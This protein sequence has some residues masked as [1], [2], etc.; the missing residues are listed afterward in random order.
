MMGATAAYSAMP[1]FAQSDQAV[2]IEEMSI[3]SEDAP[4]TLIEYASFTC[5][6]CK[7]FHADVLPEI[8]KNYIDTGKVRMIY[9][10]IYFDRLGL[11]ADMVAHCG[12]PDRYFGIAAMIYKKQSEW[13]AAD[14]AVGVVENLYTIGRL[15]GLDQADMEVCMQDNVTAQ[16]MVKVSTENA[17]AHGVNATPTFVIN[18]KTMSNM[19]YSGF[20]DEF[21]RILAE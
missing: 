8:T 18:G 16:A 14:S 5:P 12:G 3:G 15:A 10:G 13:T 4:I 1:A 17:D 9:R 19:A 21:E 20:V 11:W 7:D 6:H 2:V